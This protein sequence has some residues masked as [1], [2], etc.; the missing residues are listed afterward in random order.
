MKIQD[1][2]TYLLRTELT[3]EQIFAYSQAWYKTRTVMLVEVISDEGISGFGEAYGPA[4]GNRAIVEELYKPL[5]LGRDPLDTQVLWEE[6]Y[7]AFRDYGRKGMPVAAL[8]AVD[9]ALWDLK[10]K[11]LGLPIYKLLGGP[12]RKEVQ[13]YATGLYRRQVPDQAKALAEE[14]QGYVAEGFRAMKVKVGFGIEEDVR[15]VKAVREA[16]GPERRL[17]VDANHAYDAREAI[18]LGRL[19]EPFDIYWF[20]EPVVPEDLDGYLQVKQALK[21]PIAGGE[22][23]YTR[24]GFRELLSKRAVDIVQPDLCA[25]GG[26]SEAMKIWTLAS[27][28]GVTYYPHVWGSAVGLYASLHL[29][30]ALPPNPLA[31][32]PTELLFELDRTPNP[33]RERLATTPLVRKGDMIEIPQGPGLGLALNRDLLKASAV[34]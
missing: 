11:A 1:V 19:I 9:I 3:G 21:I 12:F 24:Y 14:A 13:A 10:G 7:N 25:C 15:N 17:M 20:E 30:A 22:A 6:L 4:A 18:R 34:S 23:E 16:I 26:F 32:F 2:K 5:L 33:F 29:A 27:T 28:W 8:S 31:L